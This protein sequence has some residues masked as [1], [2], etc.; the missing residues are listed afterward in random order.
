MAPELLS[1]KG[2]GMDVDWWSLGILL[3]EL[4]TGRTPFSKDTQEET[5]EAIRGGD[6]QF[7]DEFRA[8]ARKELDFRLELKK[9]LMMLLLN[10]SYR[11]VVEK[12]LDR[13]PCNRA[14]NESLLAWYAAI[15]WRDVEGLKIQPPFKPAPFEISELQPLE[16]SD[17]VASSQRER[18]L[19]ADWCEIQSD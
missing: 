3:Y 15:D 10:R 11:E 13:N 16:G 9:F 1:K 14:P 17:E 12:L 18:D 5:F 7:P 19:F 6:L 8:E 2:Y 4:I